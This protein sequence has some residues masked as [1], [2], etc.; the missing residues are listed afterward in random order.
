M[1]NTYNTDTKKPAKFRITFTSAFDGTERTNFYV[2]RKAAERNLRALE[3][4][5]HTNIRFEEV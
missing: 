5:R 2:T 1:K 3:I 4:C